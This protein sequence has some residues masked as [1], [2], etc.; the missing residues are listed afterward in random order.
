[1]YVVP[2]VP[3]EKGC[4]KQTLAENEAKTFFLFFFLILLIFSYWT[5][6]VSWIIMLPKRAS[7]SDMSKENYVIEPD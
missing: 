4:F 5:Q 6:R 7:V 3:Y 1:M 2:T